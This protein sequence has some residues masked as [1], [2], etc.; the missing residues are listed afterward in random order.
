MNKQENKSTPPSLNRELVDV[1]VD[2][3][4]QNQSHVSPIK[5]DAKPSGQDQA[6]PSTLTKEQ[7]LQK[8]QEYG[9]ESQKEEGRIIEVEDASEATTIKWKTVQTIMYYMGDWKH[10]LLM[11][12]LEIVMQY[13]EVQKEYVLGEWGSSEDQLDFS[14]NYF[15]QLLKVMFA[16]S[17]VACLL[18]ARERYDDSIRVLS[19]KLL[20]H[21]MLAKLLNAPINTFFDVQPIGAVLQKF[22]GD[23]G[24]FDGVAGNAFGLFW[25][26]GH[27]IK[28]FI[29]IILA[30]NKEIVLIFP[31]MA[32]YAY[33][34]QTLQ[35]P[36][37]RCFFRF[38][39][40]RSSCGAHYSEMMRGATTI[41]ALGCIEYEQN[42]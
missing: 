25:I 33:R 22:Q 35:Q 37:Q 11:Y 7:K 8:L 13:F 6:Y 19:Q 12:G 20:H 15:H 38:D 4:A 18:I 1:N 34:K 10:I 2:E 30:G 39:K 26:S 23:T 5:A 31:L 24:H 36:I 42:I 9:Q 40:E 17:V 3:D 28:I 29:L 16:V 14:K 41:R 32:W 21:D 27:I